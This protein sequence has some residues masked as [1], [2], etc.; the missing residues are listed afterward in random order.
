MYTMQWTE[1]IPSREWDDALFE[2]DGHFLQSSHWAAF[3]SQLGRRVFY[4]YGPS[5]QCLAIL[6]TA[7]TGTRLYCPYGPLA[8]N[9]KGLA[10]ALEALRQLA[11]E[12]KAVFVRLEP[13]VKTSPAQLR[14][15]GLK[16]A[17]KDIQPRLTWVQNLR[18]SEDELL[19]DMTATNRNLYRNH[20]TKGLLLRA[21]TD[22]K[23]IK[24]FI[25]M[26]AE[27]AMRNQ[28]IQH[29]DKYYQTMAEVLMPRG[30]AKLYVA[31]HEGKPVASALCL[32]SPVTRYYTHAAALFAARKLHPGTPL[33]VTMI[34]AAKAGGQTEFDFVGVA[35]A[36][37]PPGHR[38]AGLTKFKQ[39]FGGDYK[40]YA[41]T[42]ELPVSAIRYGLYRGLYLAKSK[43][44]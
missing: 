44:K 21:S 1:G 23:E 4:A 15:L 28:I 31:E 24:I 2:A 33:L 14:E 8:K 39:S 38:W 16:P 26:M 34:L 9:T 40:A 37:A 42:W 10:S 17:F 32:D 25:K 5:W 19:A 36:D 30:A 29:P 20:Q 6:E 41:G 12:Q 13:N 18:S 27:V 3:N 35:P 43:L 11:K 22:P 7:R